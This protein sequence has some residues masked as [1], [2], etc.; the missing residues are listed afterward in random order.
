M[1]SPNLIISVNL[2]TKN[3]KL[4]M[5]SPLESHFQRNMIS[6]LKNEKNKNKETHRNINLITKNI[7]EKDRTKKKIK[8]TKENPKKSKKTNHNN[9]TIKINHSFNKDKNPKKLNDNEISI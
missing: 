5:N 1:T 4:V 9:K 6:N 2:K 7:I 3:K 8:E